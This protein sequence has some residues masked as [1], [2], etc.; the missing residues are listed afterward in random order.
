ML[1][2]SRFIYYFTITFIVVNILQ[3][4]AFAQESKDAGREL[5]APWTMGNIILVL[6]AI[7]LFSLTVRSSRRDFSAIPDEFGVRPNAK[8]QKKK[9]GKQKFDFS[10]GPIKHPDLERATNLTIAAFFI[11][12]VLLFSIPTATRVRDEINGDPRFLGEGTAKTLVILNF[13][14]IGWWALIFIVA[15]IVGVV[16]VLGSG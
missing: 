12:I 8:N 3:P 2:L 7:A 1:Q 15:I 16:I 14:A 6:F 5:E 11:P 9:K 4:L 13:C 10:Q